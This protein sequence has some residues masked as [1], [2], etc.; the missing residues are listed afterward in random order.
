MKV[1]KDEDLRI[2]DPYLKLEE[3]NTTKEATIK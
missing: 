3:A 1:T 2:V